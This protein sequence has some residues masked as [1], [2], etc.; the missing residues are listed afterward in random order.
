MNPP[1]WNHENQINEK[2]SLE[3]RIPQVPLQSSKFR[4][5]IY[6][7]RFFLWASPGP[8]CAIIVGGLE[9]IGYSFTADFLVAFLF[10]ALGIGY[11]DAF[12]SESVTKENGAPVVKEALRHACYFGWLLIVVAPLS[13]AIIVGVVASFFLLSNAIF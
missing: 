2:F 10:C 4:P 8:S 9:Y 5:S 13:V 12:L 7:S 6:W 11:C 1:D 3:K